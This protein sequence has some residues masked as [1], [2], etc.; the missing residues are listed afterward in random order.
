MLPNY[1]TPTI[2]IK[3][4][5]GSYVE[6]F[7]GKKYLDLLAGIAVSSI[8]HSHPRMV[9]AI[10]KQASQFI[11]TSNIYAHA[12]GIELASK[13]LELAASAGKVLFTQD[14][15]TANEA[16][17]KIARRYGAGIS[18]SK[19]VI[20]AMNGGFHGRTFGALAVTGNAA[21]RDPFGPF[22]HEVRFVDLGDFVGLESAISGDVA[23]V[24]VES[25]QGEGGVIVPPEGWLSKIRELTLRHQSLMI[26][27]EVQSGIGR[28]G[29]WFQSIAEGVRPD[30]I[31]LAKGLGGG[32]PL[33]AVLVEP[34]VAQ[35]LQPGDH[36]TTFGG[37]P[38][39]CA[40]ALAVIAEIEDENLLE[41]VRELGSW[42]KSELL[43]MNLEHVEEVR[44]KGL[45]LAIKFDAD[46]AGAF[47]QSALSSGFL[48]NAVRSDAIRLAPPLNVSQSELQTFLDVFPAI[49]K[50]VCNV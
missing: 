36:G 48:L 16:A 6:D 35:L 25:I 45:W 46:V 34:H 47:V 37:N 9:D 29:D 33:G 2:A 12:P 39:S 19:Q 1:A 20:V 31:T 21:K 40:A 23:A 11:H 50:E 4:A 14:G 32:M 42:L 17:L 24:I 28:T 8:G 3:R 38:V 7:S 26:V 43:G 22:G 5:S 27:D 44:G 18:P 41:R 15:A 10:T 49:V 13:L 30:I